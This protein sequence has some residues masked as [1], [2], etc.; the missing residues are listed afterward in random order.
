MFFLLLIPYKSSK[1]TY[2][3]IGFVIE[4][5]AVFLSISNLKKVVVESLL[6][7]AHFLSGSFQGFLDVVSELVIK[8]SVELPP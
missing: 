7:N 2:F 3:G 1:L 8:A 4:I 6:C 5:E